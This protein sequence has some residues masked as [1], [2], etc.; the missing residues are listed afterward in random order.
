[1]PNLPKQ[2]CYLIHFGQ[3]YVG[4]PSRP[5]AKLVATRHYL[6]CSERLAERLEEHA[7]ARFLRSPD[8]N[9][10]ANTTTGNA[11][12]ILA[13]ANTAGIPWWLVRLWPGGDYQLEIALKRRKRHQDLCPLCNPAQAVHLLADP[14]RQYGNLHYRQAKEVAY[15]D[16]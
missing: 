2:A 12:V 3:P 14:D 8:N 16:R 9:P 5:G 15:A 6:G 13:A 7:R 11:A 1:M 10:A 4:L